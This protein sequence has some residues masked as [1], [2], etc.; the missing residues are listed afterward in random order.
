[1]RIDQ[2]TLENEMGN[3][4]KGVGKDQSAPIPEEVTSELG[5]SILEGAL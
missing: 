3:L 5:G 4:K 2:A 1:L